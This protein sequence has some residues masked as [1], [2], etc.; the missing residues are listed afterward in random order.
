VLLVACV[1]FACWWNI[2]EYTSPSRFVPLRHV[3][4]P[5]DTQSSQKL[6]AWLE[7]G[8]AFELP[9]QGDFEFLDTE[10]A[11]IVGLRVFLG[12]GGKR[13]SSRVN[14]SIESGGLVSRCVSKWSETLKD[15]AWNLFL[16]HCSSENTSGAR[17]E[18]FHIPRQRAVSV[19]FATSEKL[20]L[21]VYASQQSTPTI[22]V[23]ALQFLV[24]RYNQDQPPDYLE[25]GLFGQF[26]RWV[27]PLKGVFTIGALAIVLI[28]ISFIASYFWQQLKRGYSSSRQISLCFFAIWVLLISLFSLVTPPFQNPDEP[29]HALGL[30]EHHLPA[31][32]K[33]LFRKWLLADAQEHNFLEAKQGQR[34][35]ILPSYKGQVGF[36]DSDFA[37]VPRERSLAYDSFSGVIVPFIFKVLSLQTAPSSSAL[38]ALR[39]GMALF[40][41]LLISVL[42]TALVWARQYFAL[43]LLGF[44]MLNPVAVS[45]LTSVSNY[46]WAIAV[47]GSCVACLLASRR[48]S[49]SGLFSFFAGFLAI[50]L[51][52]SATPILLFAYIIPVLAGLQQLVY[53]ETISISELVKKKPEAAKKVMRFFAFPAGYAVG[54]LLLGSHLSGKISGALSGSVSLFLNHLPEIYGPPLQFLARMFIQFPSVVW[55]CGWLFLFLVKTRKKVGSTLPFSPPESIRYQWVS[56]IGLAVA[57][58]GFVI[59]LS[60][61]FSEP[62]F[63]PNIYGLAGAAKPEFAEFAAMC[64]KAFWSQFVHVEQDYFLWQTNFLAYGWLDTVAPQPVYF[65]LKV[66]LGLGLLFCFASV[67]WKFRAGLALV[68]IP[69]VF[70]VLSW[71]LLL[72]GA[73]NQGHTLLGRYLLPVFGFYALPFFN[74]LAILFP[75]SGYET[76]VYPQV[77]IVFFFVVL[78]VAGIIY[79]IPQRFMVG[80]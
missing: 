19:K 78:S 22:P 21:A 7:D 11:K 57:A 27:S 68:A 51:A 61:K 6:L 31:N 69:L 58:L 28:L 1:V 73:W 5:S 63:A 29:Q 35:P 50:I 44:C 2:R 23:P 65:V 72:Y 41:F 53:A 24:S 15:N 48:G 17:D 43:S 42:F 39:I 49:A 36:A 33:D 30:L 32:H 74:S 34:A 25:V 13:V 26:F 76:K 54:V 38:W 8:V 67:L 14:V 20:P 9:L 77:F 55:F 71:F 62:Y 79:F 3:L 56:I 10:I 70:S 60:R 59:F 16:F 12:T 40:P 4:Y 80:G 52:D 66:G 64:A 45:L 75:R 37:V 46:G 47:G 18:S